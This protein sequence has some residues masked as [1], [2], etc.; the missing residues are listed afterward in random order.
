MQENHL[1]E[2][3]LQN[4]TVLYWHEIHCHYTGL[5]CTE[6]YCTIQYSTEQYFTALGWSTLCSST[7]YCT[8]LYWT[9]LQCSASVSLF[10][11]AQFR[12]KTFLCVKGRIR[13]GLHSSL[14]WRGQCGG[15]KSATGQWE[16]STSRP[17]RGKDSTDF[18]TTTLHPLE[19]YCCL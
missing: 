6:K 18:L 4:P 2:C 7:L 10:S 14:L 5:H 3:L 1:L 8:I 13:P 11:P 15:S 16:A 19:L 17:I 9:L 12:T